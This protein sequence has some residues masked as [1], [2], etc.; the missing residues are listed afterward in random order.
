MASYIAAPCPGTRAD[1]SRTCTTVETARLVACMAAEGFTSGII[2][3]GAATPIVSPV[4]V[5]LKRAKETIDAMK[6]RKDE[7]DAL[8]GHCTLIT[9]YVIVR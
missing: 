3:V 4:F 7:L 1:A 8:H 9:T 6:G 2:D 5:L